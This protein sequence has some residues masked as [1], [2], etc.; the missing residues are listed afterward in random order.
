VGLLPGRH[1]EQDDDHEPRAVSAVPNRDE[2]ARFVRRTLAASSTIAVVDL[3]APGEHFE[4]SRGQTGAR[5]Q[6][7]QFAVRELGG[8]GAL[9]GG[10]SLYPPPGPGVQRVIVLPHDKGNWLPYDE[11]LEHTL[12]GLIAQI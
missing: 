5:Y 9:A 7:D 4:P 3:L 1:D 6:P 11:T 12:S 10:L 2:L 8:G